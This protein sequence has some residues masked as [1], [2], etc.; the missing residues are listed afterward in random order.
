MQMNLVQVFDGQDDFC[1]VNSHLAFA[2][3][4]SLVQVREQLS[5]AHVIYQI[6]YTQKNLN[7]FINSI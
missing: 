6:Y 3:F 4:L 1:D 5:T 7:S 2:E